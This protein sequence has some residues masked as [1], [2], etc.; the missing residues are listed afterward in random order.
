MGRAAAGFAL[1]GYL[2]VLATVTLGASPQ[3]A[4]GWLTDA[5][6]RLTGLYGVTVGDVERAANVLLFI[7]A[8]LLLCGL[9]PRTSRWVV[10]LVC[11]TVSV[12]V[13]AAQ[14]LLPGRQS[15]PIDVV[16]NSTGGAL[17]VL[18]HALLSRLHRSGRG[19]RHRQA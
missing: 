16:T 12:G 18:L 4:L 19:R 5:V 3:A 2:V 15:S 9:L 8:G 11:L 7:P 6:H 1:I 10:W 14:L 13:E 17:G